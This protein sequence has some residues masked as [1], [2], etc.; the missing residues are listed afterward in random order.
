MHTIRSTVRVRNDTHLAC[1]RWTLG[2]SPRFGCDQRCLALQ[3]REPTTHCRRDSTI[4]RRRC[5]LSTRRCSLDS[6]PP[7]HVC[8]EDSIK[9]VSPHVTKQK[10]TIKLKLV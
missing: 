10:E 5:P 9:T 7:S 3:R 8:D 4:V 1:R 2:Q 6:S